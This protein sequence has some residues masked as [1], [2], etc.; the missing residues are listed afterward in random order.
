MQ[1]KAER[2]IQFWFSHDGFTHYKSYI[3]HA[4]VACLCPP[5]Q[6]TFHSASD[7]EVLTTRFQAGPVSGNISRHKTEACSLNFN[8][9]ASNIFSKFLQSR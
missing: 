1:C 8:S 9:V 3:R 6:R 5:F 2:L 4:I 7:T